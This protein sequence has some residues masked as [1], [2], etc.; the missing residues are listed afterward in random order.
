LNAVLKRKMRLESPDC[1]IKKGVCAV[2]F[3]EDQ[4]L[5]VTGGVAHRAKSARDGSGDSYSF[6]ELKNGQYLLILSDGM[7]SGERARRESAATVGLL[8]DFL[9]SGFDKELAVRMINSVLVLKSSEECFSTLDICSLDL[10][11]GEAEFTKIGAASTFLLRNGKVSVIRSSSLPMGMLNSV[12]AEISARKLVNDDII[13]MVT[14]GVAEAAENHPDKE[15][16]LVETLHG[17]RFR[18]PQDVADYI[19][20]EAERA[21]SGPA[22]DDMTVLAARVWERM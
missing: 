9:D 13:V 1:D 20:E 4:K 22:R 10:Y 2:R 11:T 14:D 16:W 8:E 6:M 3:V 19:L 17:C 5:R 18:H 7:G 21:Q 15:G 12:D